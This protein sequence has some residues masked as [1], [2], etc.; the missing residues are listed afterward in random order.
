MHVLTFILWECLLYGTIFDPKEI[1]GNIT[2]V[3]G[4]LNEFSKLIALR[5]TFRINMKKKKKQF[6]VL[7]LGSTQYEI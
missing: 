2:E 3:G 6:N 4:E 7:Y 5:T 1:L